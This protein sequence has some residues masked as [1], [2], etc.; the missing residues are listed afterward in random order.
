MR[1]WRIVLLPVLLAAL[2]ASATP[3]A[4]AVQD[5]DDVLVDYRR[6]GGFAGFDD[7]VAVHRDGCAWLSRRAKPAVRRCLTGEERRRLLAYLKDVTI[8]PSEPRPMG[9]DFLAYTLAY[10]GHRAT[11]YSL[12]PSWRPVV[13]E[14]DRLMEKYR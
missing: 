2:T 3:P 1:I 4:A 12:P 7:R 9:A 14:L 6:Q 5:Q 10:G 11:R 8:G 13:E